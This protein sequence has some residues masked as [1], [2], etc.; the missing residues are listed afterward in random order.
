MMMKIGYCRISTKEQNFNLQE[1]ALQKEGCEKIYYDVVSGAKAKRKGLDEML[2]HLRDGDIVVV[3][4]IDRLGRS[5]RHLVELIN[6][7]SESGIGLKSLND[8]V[9]TT[10][11]QG[12]L[13]T[14]IFASIAEFERELI[15]ERTK[16]G[17]AAARARGRLGGR[18]SGLSKSAISKAIVAA[19][20]Y[21]EGELS[22]KEITEHL[23]ISKS[24]LYKYLRYRNVDIGKYTKSTER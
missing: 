2:S 6:T 7:L 17:L 5:L 11:A 4:K 20:L 9:D 8:P 10:S 18:K 19:T 12:R 23:R 1:D 24:T 13:V 14:N 15:Q 16:S 3:Y 21:T 22:V